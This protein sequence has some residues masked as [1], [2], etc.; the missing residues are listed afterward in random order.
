MKKLLLCL[1]LLACTTHWALAVN[2]TSVYTQKPNDPDAV[3]FTPENYNIKADGKTDVSDQLQAVINKLKSEEN[4]GIVFIPEG[5]YKITKT[6][7]IPK[8]IRLIGYGKQRPVFVLG[9]NSPGFQQPVDTDKGKAKY[10]FWFTNNVVKDESR[11]DDADAGTFYS[12]MSNINLRI[13]DGNPYAVALRTHFAQHSFVSNMSIYIGKG[14]AGLFDVGNEMENVAFYGGEYG[15]YTTKTSPGWQ[16]MMVDTYFEG[17]R[18]A[19]ILTQEVG[20]T[21]VNMQAKNV[22]TV[23]DIVPNHHE[24]LFME[25]SQFVNVSGP[26]IV[27]SN[28][29]NGNNQITL[30][31]VDCMKVPVLVQYRR[32]GKETTVKDKIYCVKEYN[33]GLQMDNLAASPEYRTTYDIQPLTKLPAAL[34]KDIPSLPTMDTWVNVKELGAKGDGVTDDTKA[35]QEAIDKHK[36]IYVPQGWYRLT[37]TVKMKPG[38]RLIGLHPMATQLILAES[39]PAFSGFGAPKA[40]LESSVGGNNILNGIGIS[41][42]AYN[43]RAVGCKWMADADSYLNDVKF[44]G[45]HGTMSKGPAQ[46]WR[47]GNNS[48]IS[49]PTNPVYVI[50]KDKAWDNQHWS[51]WITDNGGGTFKNVWTAN[52]Y[53]TNGVYVHNTSTPGRIYAMSI[54][55]HVRNEARFNNV[56]NWKVYAFQME[57]EDR[58]SVDCQPLEIEN[59]KNMTFANLYMYRTIRLVTPVPYS[60]RTWNCENIEF[61]NVHNYTQ[62]KYTSNLPIYDIST[63]IEVRPWEF[64]KLVLTGKEARRQPLTNEVGKVQC[65]AKGFE[66][67]EGIARDSKGNIYF[68]EQRMR[69]VYK[70]SV[71][72]NTIS[73]VADFPWQPQSLACDT[74]DNLLVIFRYDPQPGY[75][76]NGKQETV[77]ELPDAGGTSFSGW[78]NS[79]F[80]NW[81]Y[82]IDP[83]KP[84]ATIQLLPKVPYAQIKNVHKALYPSNR[85]RDY[86]DFNE[87]AVYK[88]EYC[89]VATDGVTI[90]PQCYDLARSSAVLEA[91]PG[92]PFYAS[93]EYDKRVVKMDVAQDGTLSNLKYFAERGEFGSAVDSEGNVYIAD[94]QV[95]IYDKTGKETG[96]IEVPERPSTIQF[97]GKDGNTLFI[98]G[99]S[100][101]Y[102]VRIK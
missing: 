12:A 91:Y 16:M 50:G 87:V 76:V 79:G 23:M 78:G 24:R 13:E 2:E 98:T 28:E 95:Y 29:D 97:G 92:K 102:N 10:M 19:A 9:K 47:G 58:E 21:I 101:L 7:Y 35:F 69:R 41:T 55:H 44:V 81:V 85:W 1:L 99:R 49:S 27:V 66:F 43:Y 34:A 52:T 88:P 5:T 20:F 22:P 77:P 15:I 71:E 82:S 54:E 46:P 80:A 25:N 68:S 96:M 70:W 72:T 8:S 64:Q 75:M 11:I 84:E 67:A 39:T 33:H 65:L 4:F 61:I 56:A 3:Y 14:K 17:Q 26:A 53:A 51:L 30:R 59:C 100:A 32:S 89:F 37:E 94:G 62:I 36:N 93:D 45:G 48:G 38:T 86:H 57:E 40:M 60:V 63:D 90:I 74:K 73:L 83:S 42:G 31:N 6:I 18:K